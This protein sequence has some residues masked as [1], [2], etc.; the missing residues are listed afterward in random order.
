MIP[1]A[2]NPRKGKTLKYPPIA[3]FSEFSR[4][5]EKINPPTD[6]GINGSINMLAR[7]VDVITR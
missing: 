4:R 2:G 7:Y 1:S 3:R 5:A 6:L